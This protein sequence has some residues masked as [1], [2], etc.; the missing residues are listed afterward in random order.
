MNDEKYV[1]LQDVAEKKKIGRSAFNR[2]PHGKGGGVRLPPDNLT[3]KER[4][5]M[6]GEVQSYRLNDPLKWQEY[7]KLPDDLKKIYIQQLRSRFDINDKHLMQVF[8]CSHFTV[9]NEIKRLGLGRG[10]SYRAKRFSPD[11]WERWVRGLPAEKPAKNQPEGTE[12]D[13]MQELFDIITSSDTAQK[14]LMPESVVEA[15]ETS[16]VA[17][18]VIKPKLVP[19]CGMCTFHGVAIEV[20]RVVSELLTDA[21]LEITVT[22]KRAD[23]N[24]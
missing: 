21:E 13:E 18:P 15:I 2:K 24:E 19:S 9:E 6:N 12:I 3:K 7:K 20:L 17:A 22:W 16:P 4:E 11:E 23:S 10:K 8:G 5:K 14:S 1:F